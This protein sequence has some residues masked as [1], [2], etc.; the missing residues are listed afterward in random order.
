MDILDCAFEE[1]SA[2]AQRLETLQ[3]YKIYDTSEYVE[4]KKFMAGEHI[5]GFANQGWINDV[6]TW[7]ANGKIIERIRVIPEQV[8][9]YFIYESRWCYPRNISAGESILMV[10]QKLYDEAKK[11]FGVS[12]KDVW[13]FDQKE[14]IELKYTAEFEY[15]DCCQ[16]IN[17]ESKQNLEQLYAFL[18]E[19]AVTYSAWRED[20]R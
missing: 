14:M 19:K 6:A 1:F 4:F 5:E 16:I 8:T 2:V 15:K 3:E 13:M 18:K 9:D 10:N 11:R 7:R 12:E 20:V 17:R